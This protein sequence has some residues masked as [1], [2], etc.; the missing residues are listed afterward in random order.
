M[1]RRKSNN[2]YDPLD[3][4]SNLRLSQA[5]V[6]EQRRERDRRGAVRHILGRRA[7]GEMEI[8]QAADALDMLGLTGTAR[9]MKADLVTQRSED[10]RFAQRANDAALSKQDNYDTESE[11]DDS[12]GAGGEAQVAR[13]R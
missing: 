4:A 7:R 1:A 2:V 6:D 10:L 8:S 5:L 11:N 12:S 13:R 9:E 3:S